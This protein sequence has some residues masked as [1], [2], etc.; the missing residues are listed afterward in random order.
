MILYTRSGGH[1][2]GII[3]APYL[4]HHSLSRL[5][6]R[7]IVLLYTSSRSLSD[8]YHTDS[9][10]SEP[11]FFE[12][13]TKVRSS[14]ISHP[15]GSYCPNAPL[16]ANTVSRMPTSKS[17]SKVSIPPTSVKPLTIWSRSSVS[18]T[19]LVRCPQLI[20]RS[21]RQSRIYRCPE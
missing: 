3:Y 1:I 14:L 7:S 16:T 13:I 4:V 5:G 17:P 19:R 18:Y 21:I 11:Q 9:T 6:S 20:N 12:T 8:Q 15:K 2:H 10:M